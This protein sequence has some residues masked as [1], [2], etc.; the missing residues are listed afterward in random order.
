MRRAR[1]Q[2]S[3]THYHYVSCRSSPYPSSRSL[4]SLLTQ[5]QFTHPHFVSLL[6]YFRGYFS[7]PTPSVTPRLCI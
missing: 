2:N 6:L 5:I 4:E 3:K 1:S 7:T